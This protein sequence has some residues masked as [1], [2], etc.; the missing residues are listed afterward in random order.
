MT[1]SDSEPVASPPD[2]VVEHDDLALSQLFR[3]LAVALVILLIAAFIA[4]LT[5]KGPIE[6][7]SAYFVSKFGL[8][9]IFGGIMFLDAVPFTTHEPLLLLGVQGGLGFW[10]V[11]LVAG[12]ASTLSGFVGWTM[13]RI[14]GR[15]AM[16]R[17]WMARYKVDRFLTRYGVWAIAIAATTPFPFAIC[18]W[19]CG[20]ANVPLPRVMFGSLFRF[21]KVLFYQTLMVVGFNL[22]DIAAMFTG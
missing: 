4:G 19:S 5:L 21:P 8:A 14:V 20:A 1:P 12:T 10:P 6:A 16:V 2:L 3:Q 15:A 9:G 11:F 17:R 13:G 22:E 18:T 7:A